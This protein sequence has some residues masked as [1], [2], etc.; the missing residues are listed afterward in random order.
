[1]ATITTEH[2]AASRNRADALA[3][4]VRTLGEGLDTKSYIERAGEF[5]AF[6]EALPTA[7]GGP[8]AADPR[9]RT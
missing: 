9:P 7:S 5:V 8:S 2:D 3:L 1:M 6:I 4:A